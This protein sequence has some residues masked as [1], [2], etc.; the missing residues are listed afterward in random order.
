MN[1]VS[2]QDFIE[3]GNCLG[4]GASSFRYYEQTDWMR[5]SEQAHKSISL[6]VQVWEWWKELYIVNP[7]F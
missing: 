1:T 4:F 2:S 7:L 3:R 5:H 6:L